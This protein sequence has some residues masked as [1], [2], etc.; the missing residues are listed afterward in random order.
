MKFSIKKIKK[1]AKM[2]K[3]RKSYSKSKIHAKSHFSLKTHFVDF[4]ILELREE[5]ESQ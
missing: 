1:R 3:S 4:L 5:R 2:K